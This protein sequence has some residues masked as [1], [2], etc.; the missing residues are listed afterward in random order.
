MPDTADRLFD[1]FRHPDFLS[2][3]GLANEVPIFIH[4]YDPAKEDGVRRMVD[5]L[6]SRLRAVGIS[7]AVVDLFDLILQ[8]LEEEKRLQRIIDTEVTT[9]KPKLLALLSN[10]SDPETRLVPRL[11]RSIGD[12]VQLTLL[13]GAGQVYPFLRTHTVLEAIQPAMA[14]HPIVLFFP[15]EYVQDGNGSQLLL[16]GAQ[17]IPRL[18]RP[19]YRAINLDHYRP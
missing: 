2:L 19:Y 4:T 15:G 11:M 16:F 6:A 3:K 8:Q 1:T 18:N 5:H 17:P 7:L 12:E 10:L 13:T 9:G 14:H